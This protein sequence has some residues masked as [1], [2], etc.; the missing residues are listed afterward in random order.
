MFNRANLNR[1]YFTNRQDRYV[2]I[3]NCRPLAD[4]FDGVVDKVCSMSSQL[5]ADGE[6]VPSYS[7]KN[8]SAYLS[9]FKNKITGYYEEYLG[10]KSSTWNNSPGTVIYYMCKLCLLFKGCCCTISSYFFVFN[11]N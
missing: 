1:D 3:K 2:V 11:F 5:N 9:E 10:G 8:K 4:F 6:I 7:V